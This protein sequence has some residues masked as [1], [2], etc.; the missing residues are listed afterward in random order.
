MIK[1]KIMAII[2]GE[3]TGGNREETG[4]FGFGDG[5]PSSLDSQTNS[6]DKFQRL[7]N[8]KESSNPS[9]GKKRKERPYGTTADVD[10]NDRQLM[11]A[12]ELAY[13]YDDVDKEELLNDLGPGWDEDDTLYM[14]VEENGFSGRVFINKETKQVIIAYR[15]TDPDTEY[16]DIKSDLGL[17]LGFDINQYKSARKFYQRVLSKYEDKGYSFAQ[18]GHSLGGHLAQ[19][20]ALENKI[21]T[22]SFNGPGFVG[23]LTKKQMR[24]DYQGKYDDLVINYV[25]SSDQI[26]TY[27]FHVGK[28]YAFDENG[29]NKV[30]EH[31][32]GQ[33]FKKSFPAKIP[34]LLWDSITGLE[35]HGVKNIRDH[36]EEDGSTDVK[37]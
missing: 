26:G 1:D 6:S 22:F 32:T 2:N 9:K 36:M 8:S 13:D 28:T 20:M 24:K 21:P 12:T 5:K 34:M 29:S 33:R 14:D 31:G 16:T 27:G 3:I 19:K 37:R 35:H 23:G 30:D 18:V 17:G 15:G 11:A 7:S 25:D 4:N 10:L